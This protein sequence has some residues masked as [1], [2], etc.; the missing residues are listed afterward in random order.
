[1]IC[2]YHKGDLDGHCAG[3]IV[4]HHFVK[5]QMVGIDYEDEFPWNQVEPEQTIVMVDFSLPMEDMFRLKGRADPLKFIWIDHHKTAIDKAKEAGFD[6]PGLRMVGKAACELTWEYFFP[7]KPMPRAVHL[8]GR[9]DV[10]DEAQPNWQSE[11]LPFQYGLR[12]YQTDPSKIESIHLWSKLLPKSQEGF[13]EKTRRLGS[14]IL[15]YQEIENAK[16][17]ARH[18]F[19]TMLDDLVAL[20]VNHG[21]GGSMKFEQATPASDKP[22][23]FFVQNFP[24]LISFARLPE[25]KWLVNLYTFRGDVDCGEI[26]RHHGGG[27]HRKAAGFICEGELPFQI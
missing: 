7:D 14:R 5:P 1:M 15:W 17:M 22:D 24:L 3:A 4:R 27:G 16:L 2:F 25:K 18:A 8:L 26:A 6:T 12:G 20:V 21:P 19:V 13:I 11:I 9:Y 10:Y 23:G